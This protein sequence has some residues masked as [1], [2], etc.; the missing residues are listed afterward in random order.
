[1]LFQ[2]LRVSLRT[3][4]SNPGFTLVALV[5]LALGTGANTAIFSVLDALVFRTLPVEKP[6]ELVVFGDTRGAG[7]FGGFPNGRSV[8]YSRDFFDHLNATQKIFSGTAA[9]A[10]LTAE[11]H[12]RFTSNAAL[13]PM[14]IR[15]VSD[16]YFPLLGIRPAAG[17]FF[18]G[19]KTANEAVMS[20]AYWQRR[21]AGDPNVVG[22]SVAIN[23]QAYTITGVASRGF[24]GT[25]VGESPDFWTPLESQAQ[26]QPWTGNSRDALAQSLWL[27]ARLAPGVTIGS[28]QPQVDVIYR[29]W[30]ERVAGTSPE[31][32]AAIP[33]AKAE[34]NEA[35]RG[36]SLLRRQYSEPLHILLAMVGLIL[37][38]ASANIANLL[39]ARVSARQREASVRIA[40]G[41]TRGRLIAQLLTESVVLSCLGGVLG[42]V[43]AVWAAPYLVSLVSSDPR[44]VQ[45][46]VGLQPLVLGFHVALCLVTGLLFG[47]WPALRLSRTP[48]SLQAEGKGTVANA[49]SLS[50]RMLVVAQVALALVLTAGAGWFFQTLQR[51]EQTNPGFDTQSTLFVG[52]DSNATGLP[53]SE[54]LRQSERIEAKLNTLPGVAAASYTMV[55]Y[56]AGRWGAPA[57]PQG[58]PRDRNSN[59]QRYDGNRVGL[60]YFEVTGMRLLAGRLFSSFDSPQAERVVVL[61]E[62]AAK[63]LYPAGNAVGQLVYLSRESSSA[64]RIIGIVSDA[65]I[66]N[67]RETFG[68]MIFQYNAQQ[69]DGYSDLLVRAAAGVQPESLIPQV[70]NLLRQENP[71]LAITEI[72]TMG[73]LFRRSLTQER[74]LAKL[75]FWFGVLALTLAAVG[76]YGVLAYSVARRT[77]EI[78]V[79]MALGATPA[80]VVRMVLL[81]SLA[82]SLIGVAAGMPAVWGAGRLVQ[83]QLYGLTPADPLVLGASIS[84]LLFSAVLAA[85]VPSLRASRMDPLG[86]LRND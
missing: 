46:D 58:V 15:I 78:G 63:R 44:G 24:A 28:A 59:T 60:R 14:Q 20:Y 73:E 8:L 81:E 57:W 12:G 3:L 35:S 80:T 51:L 33:R 36:T 49:N 66:E 13:E 39:L 83:T 38:I 45:L 19:G 40:L 6:Q 43:L 37:L 41:A 64:H 4:A 53:E 50:G 55:H 75:A 2:D 56:D 68:G 69:Q 42:L 52:L 26:L 61:S 10:S 18:T 27:I 29:Q 74:M 62:T 5:S 16:S 65:K 76:I 22:R 21:F 11:A 72:T 34:L 71:N 25:V 79:R 67:P 32:I 9:I 70:R 82:M 47:W 85:L 30:L 7:L 54:Q 17:R 77:A 1:M 48:A 86:A 23:G 31:R 84:I